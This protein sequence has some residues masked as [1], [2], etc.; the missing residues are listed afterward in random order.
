MSEQPLNFSRKGMKSSS[1]LIILSIV[2]VAL[3][4]LDSRYSA[5]Q[6]IK[7]YT[8][9]AL[10]PLQWIA[11]QPVYFYRYISE[12]A[13]SQIDLVAESKRLNEENGRLKLLL[14]QAG[15][16]Q[17]ELVELKRLQG[18]QQSGIRIAG[19]ATVISNGR[20]PLSDRLILN[21]GE[22]SG[23]KVGDAAVDQ[24]GLIGQITQVHPLSAELTL[25]TNSKTVI[26]IMVERTGVRSLLY[27]SGG[28]INLRYFPADADLRP[29][30]VLVT[31]G[32]DSI[33][34]EGIPVAKVLQVFRA[35]GTPYYRVTLAPLS[36]FR[37]SKY[38]LVLPQ[39]KRPEQLSPAPDLAQAKRP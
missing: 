21:K 33:Y 18:L 38:V 37:N 1:K 25:I 4:M 29:D 8:A 35:A 11:N 32:L 22:V 13:Q 26:P 19:M 23:F 27:G 6:K 5:V 9:T 7:G 2:S 17:N 15:I 28:S 39:K 36:G 12:L 16:Q 30:D 34:P 24:N 31:S 10:Y 14:A 20:D 3:M